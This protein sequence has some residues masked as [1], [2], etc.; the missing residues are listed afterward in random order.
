MIA[1]REGFTQVNFGALYV[2]ERIFHIGVAESVRITNK[3]TRFLDDWL[4]KMNSATQS[5]GT[6]LNQ[7]SLTRDFL[8]K[9]DGSSALFSIEIG[10]SFFYK[11]SN[12]L[13]KVV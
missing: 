2:T 9:N 7:M 8:T 5:I 1:M 3:F 13:S 12:A 6:R 11:C 10:W 4:L